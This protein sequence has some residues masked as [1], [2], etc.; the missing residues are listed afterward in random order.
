MNSPVHSDIVGRS[1]VLMVTR[2]G[3]KK[4]KRKKGKKKEKQS[5]S[6]ISCYQ[7]RSLDLLHA[8]KPESGE[9]EK[10]RKKWNLCGRSRTTSAAA[11]ARDSRGRWPAPPPSPISITPSNPPGRFGSTRSPSPSPL[12][13]YNPLLLGWS[14]SYFLCIDWCE[15]MARGLRLSSGDRH[16]IPLHLPVSP[17][18][19]S[20]FVLYLSILCS[21]HYVPTAGVLKCSMD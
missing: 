1:G 4:K 13:P 12:L 19:L 6:L 3:R 10:G 2:E 21:A 11:V 5:Y 7:R 18:H 8:S 17:F 14:I 15:W 20:F 16:R 9:S